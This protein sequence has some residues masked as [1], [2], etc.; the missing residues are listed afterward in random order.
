MKSVEENSKELYQVKSVQGDMLDKI[1]VAVIVVDHYKNRQMD[2]GLLKGLFLLE[3]NVERRDGQRFTQKFHHIWIGFIQKWI[4][5]S[6]EHIEYIYIVN[7]QIIKMKL[8][9]ISIP[10]F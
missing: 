2:N 1:V 7:N 9:K 6:S 4:K 5:C 8:Y 10:K 3:K